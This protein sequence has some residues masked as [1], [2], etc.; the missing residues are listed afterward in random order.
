[1]TASD[2]GLDDLI[3][4]AWEVREHAHAPYSHYLVGA[5]ARTTEGRVFTGANVENASYPVGICAERVAGAAASAA[6]SRDLEAVAVVTS[7]PRPS[8]PCGMCRQFLFEFN[9]DMTIVSEGTNGERTTWRLRDLLP[10]GFGPTD[11]EEAR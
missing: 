4:A 1:M 10:E 2:P 8:S 9:P 5:A 3:R 6:G 7:S 11:L